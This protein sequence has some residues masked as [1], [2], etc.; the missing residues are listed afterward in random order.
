MPLLQ[1]VNLEKDT[2]RVNMEQSN[3]PRS[4]TSSEFSSTSVRDVD[5]TADKVGL[6][7]PHSPVYSSAGKSSSAGQAEKTILDPTGKTG[8]IGG[9][10]LASTGSTDNFLMPTPLFSSSFKAKMM[11]SLGRVSAGRT[12]AS[13]V[14]DV[15]KPPPPPPVVETLVMDP[16]TV[17]PPVATKKGKEIMD[18]GFI[19]VVKKKKKFN[20]P[21]PRVQIPSLNVSK[22]GPSNPPGRARPNVDNGLSTKA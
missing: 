17:A 18:D 8:S 9:V 19:K 1:A 3:V 14:E 11:E 7:T 22:P 16:P 21:K 6:S 10:G 4:N 15:H 2:C 12:A 13:T 5:N 20:G